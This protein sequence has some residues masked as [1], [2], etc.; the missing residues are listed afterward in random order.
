[1]YHR[2]VALS[3]HR[4]IASLSS[5]CRVIALS[6]QRSIV[7]E[8]GCSLSHIFFSV[9]EVLI[10]CLSSVRQFIRL[11]TFHIFDFFHI[12]EFFKTSVSNLT[13]PGRRT[14]PGMGIISCENKGHNF[15]LK[16]R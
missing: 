9:Y 7:N 13:I 10:I 2:D 16:G 5:H 15:S 8:S 11:Y 6:Y 4:A 14:S 3:L 1:M 12:F